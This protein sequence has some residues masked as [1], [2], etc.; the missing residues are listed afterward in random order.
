MAGDQL[1]LLDGLAQHGGGAAGDILVA[2]AV[3][4]IAAD[5][6]LGIILIGQGVGVG[7]RGHGLMEGGVEHGHHGGAGHQLLAGLD[8]DDVGGVVQ[9]GQRIALLDGGHDLVGDEDGLGELLAAVDHPVAHRVDLLH[10]ADDAVLLVYQGVQHG[11]DGLGVG[12]HGHVGR[13][14]GLL[15]GGFVGELAVNADALAQALGQNLLGL[16]VEQLILQGGA[17]GID[18]KNVHGN[19]SPFSGFCCLVRRNVLNWNISLG[20]FYLVFVPRTTFF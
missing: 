11:L 19:Q 17:A 10:G 6:V 20:L 12:G 4:A 9:G 18:H 8:A 1:Q 5:L 16:R 7:H 15:A 13:L 2:G 14:D 3:E